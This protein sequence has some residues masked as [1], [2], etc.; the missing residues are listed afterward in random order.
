MNMKLLGMMMVAGV[1]ATVGCKQQSGVE[2]LPKASLG[3]KTE[4]TVTQVK[5]T[6]IRAAT[7]VVE[8]TK[9]AAAEM[10]AGATEAADTAAEKTGEMVE[11]TG[12]AVEKA[13]EKLQN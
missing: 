7:N 3:E 10:K 8:K 4:E 5:Q 1:V 2:T 13:G 12:E 11:K 9:E 6:T